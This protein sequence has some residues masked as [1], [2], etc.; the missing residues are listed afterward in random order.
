MYR[1]RR[2]RRRRVKDGIRTRLWQSFR[3]VGGGGGGADAAAAS[4]DA[5][6]PRLRARSPE[7]GSPR[8]PRRARGERGTERDGERT[9]QVETGRNFYAC[10]AF[11][12]T[13][14]CCEF[15]WFSG[16]FGFH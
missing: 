1:R 3:K 8:V 12:R 5:L 14:F 4:R 15:F 7:E 10:G 13:I 16:R 2:R 9:F 11:A 6:S